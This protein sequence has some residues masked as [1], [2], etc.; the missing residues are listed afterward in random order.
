[1]SKHIQKKLKGNNQPVKKG[2][3]PNTTKIGQVTAKRMRDKA[4]GQKEKQ[5]PKGFDEEIDSDIA[6]DIDEGDHQM[7][8][9]EKRKNRMGIAGDSFFDNPDAEKNETIE[10]RRLRMTKALLAELQQP[11]AAKDDF[12]ESL[13]AGGNKVDAEV[14]IFNEQED[15]LLTKRLKYQILEKK[16]KLFYNIADHFTSGE[17]Q[18]VFLKGHKKA[19]T[20]LEWSQ[21]NRSIFT[22]S[23]DC[24]LIQWDL[25]SQKK[26]LF[27][28]EKHNRAIE[29]HFDEPLCLATNGKYL[30]SGGKDRI[31]RVWDIHN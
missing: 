13:Q 3:A 20:A 28:G 15:D 11:N 25:E 2:G 27:K 6:E 26:I 9:E 7:V 14:E 30:V 24:C 19:I 4:Q 18:T 22:A 17:L 10:E 21:D 29:G 12:F 16:G 31:V 1:M 8:N 23:K 5:R